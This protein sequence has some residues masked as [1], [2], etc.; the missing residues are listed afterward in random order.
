MDSLDD[1]SNEHDVADVIA[2]AGERWRRFGSGRA[3]QR[4]WAVR[5][6]MV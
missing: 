4:I 6:A 1:P 5:R 2:T 3:T